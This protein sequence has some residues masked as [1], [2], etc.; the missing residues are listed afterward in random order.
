MKL[1]T[2]ISAKVSLSCWVHYCLRYCKYSTNDISAALERDKC[3]K[4]EIDLYRRIAEE[5]EKFTT[6]V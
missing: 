5:A 1:P 2:Q 3:N 6:Y 4:S